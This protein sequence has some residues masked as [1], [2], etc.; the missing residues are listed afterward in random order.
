MQKLNKLKLAMGLF[1]IALYFVLIN[2]TPPQ[3]LS[4]EGLKILAFTI[5]VIIFWIFEVLPIGM[6]SVLA[7][8]LMP[9]A[10]IMKMPVVMQNFGLPTMFFILASF[11][12][13]A[14]FIKTG[15]GY[16]VSLSVSTLFGTKSHQVLL[17][18]MAATSIISMFLA[19]IPTAIV[20]SGIAYPILKKNGCEPGKSKFGMAIM[21]GIPI[22][23]CIGGFGTP[24]GSGLNVLALDLLKNNANV[25]V[26]FLQWAILGIPFAIIL[27]LIAWAILCKMVPSEIDEVKGLEDVKAEKAKLGA[28]SFEEVKFCLIFATTAILWFTSK[29]NGIPIY[30]TAVVF[31]SMLFF[32]GVDLL[33]WK[34]TKDS[35]GWDVLLLV[36]SSNAIAKA[37]MA[38]GAA[39]WI[40]SGIDFTG[41][42]MVMMLF[43]V[44][45]FG[46]FSHFIIPVGNATLAV[47]IP[48]IS[49]LA[50]QAGVSAAVLVVPL[51]YT[52]SCLFLLPVDPVPL[53]TYNYGYWKI[54]DM[55]KPGFVI[56]L[57]WVVLLT[58]FAYLAA[59]MNLFG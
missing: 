39:K 26:S 41:S 34:G 42:T 25:E 51:A 6:S 37:L 36:G 22:A 45:A 5:S 56:S 52:A 10:G 4:P 8:M 28:M 7:L 16:R 31:A 44:I 53:T 35:I 49:V 11:C 9:M 43:I 12:F 30:V 54:T 32:P 47:S 27:T 58:G 40:A 57:F 15:L 23:A 48:V 46:V 2:L 17:S 3:G 50:A 33:D 29:W 38:L 59:Q 18:F 55:M 1:A 19:D 24:A 20:F 14:G 13:A 21:M